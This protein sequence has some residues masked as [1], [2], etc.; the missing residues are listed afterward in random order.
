MSGPLKRRFSGA[1]SAAGRGKGRSADRRG[2]ACAQLSV[3]GL[4]QGE[5]AL[6][7]RLHPNMQKERTK[8]K[9]KMKMIM[10]MRMKDRGTYRG[11]IRATIRFARGCEIYSYI[12]LFFSEAF[13]YAT[14]AGP[15]AQGQ[16]TKKNRSCTKQ[17]NSGSLDGCI[18]RGAYASM[19]EMVRVVSSST[20]SRAA[21]VSR[22]VNM[23]TLYSVAI[24]RIWMPS[25]SL[26]PGSLVLIT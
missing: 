19:V 7:R 14:G 25:F 5:Q 16:R 8:E 21:T 2:T 23:V 15:A 22:A 20:S 3:K 17:H 4:A 18:Q 9:M 10:R 12:Y 11:A 26:E 24:W 6:F 1:R 13:W